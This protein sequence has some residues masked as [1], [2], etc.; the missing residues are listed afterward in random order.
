[1]G[2]VEIVVELGCGPYF[3]DFDP[4]VIGRIAL[5]EIGIFRV[6]KI[7]RDIFKK[8]GLVVLDGE[9]VMSVP[10]L[11]Q[12]FG[13]FALCQ[14]GICGDIF[15]FDIDGIKQWDSDLDF[16]GAFEFITAFYG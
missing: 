14:E 9:V 6:F 11:N 7:D 12:I 16:V 8:S 5:N 10:V 1:M 2:E 13:E 4:A 15:A 3:A